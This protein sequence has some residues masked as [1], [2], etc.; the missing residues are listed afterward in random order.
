M[1]NITLL[2]NEATLT[3]SIVVTKSPIDA[4][5]MGELGSFDFRKGCEIV[6]LSQG[7]GVTCI[8]FMGLRLDFQAK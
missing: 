5:Y 1:A 8:L 6:P 3:F 4:K 2:L 7:L